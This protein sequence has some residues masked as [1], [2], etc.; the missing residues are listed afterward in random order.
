MDPLAKPAPIPSL[1][2]PLLEVQLVCL[3]RVPSACDMRLSGGG[4]DGGASA[5]S[6][7]TAPPAGF[8]AS[9]SASSMVIGFDRVLASGFSPDMLEALDIGFT[10]VSSGGSMISSISGDECMELE[11]KDFTFVARPG[12]LLRI[13]GSLGSS[14][15]DLHLELPSAHHA[16]RR[17]REE[18]GA[19]AGQAREA[20]ATIDVALRY[21]EVPQR[22]G[23]GGA[24]GCLH[25]VGP[26]SGRRQ[27]G[28]QKPSQGILSEDG[29]PIDQ[30][31]SGRRRHVDVVGQRHP[32]VLVPFHQRFLVS[33][34]LDPL[35][36]GIRGEGV[37]HVQHVS[38]DVSV[39]RSADHQRPFPWAVA[40]AR[41]RHAPVAMQIDNFCCV[42]RLRHSRERSLIYVLVRLRNRVWVD[43]PAQ[44]AVFQGA[45]LGERHQP[46]ADGVV[47]RAAEEDEAL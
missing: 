21:V 29:R 45:V 10:P 17:A 36:S 26:A 27:A 44:L 32:R 30:A 3:A 24:H 2:P 8:T 19:A 34:R 4:P 14:N 37:R 28:S 15:F 11:W 6:S 12:D 13:L 31:V 5:G 46:D 33:P 16:I 7:S 25:G 40:G 22:G 20:K 47:P 23:H 41:D 38:A 39:L 43:E 42:A 35:Q 9:S 1:V 18:V